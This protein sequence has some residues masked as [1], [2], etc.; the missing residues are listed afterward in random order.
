MALV[1]KVGENKDFVP[2]PEGFPSCQDYVPSHQG[3][4][5]DQLVIGT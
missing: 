2:V 1:I 4:I 5:D 3:L